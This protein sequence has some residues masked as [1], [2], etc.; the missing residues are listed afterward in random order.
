[1]K[2]LKRTMSVLLVLILFVVSCLA[3]FALFHRGTYAFDAAYL[4]V[5]DEMTDSYYLQRTPRDIKFRVATA[6][7][8]ISPTYN[9]TDAAGDPVLSSHERV[10]Q[11]EYN[12]LP[13]AGG[14]AAGARYTLT[15]GDDAS[16]TDAHLKNARTL[17]FCIE[18]DAAAEYAFTDK[19]TQTATPIRQISADVISLD[20]IDAQ[21]G[22]ILFGANESNDYVVCKISEIMDDGT[23]AVTV[24]ALDEIYADLSV[25]GE[26]EFDVNELAS[27]PALEGEITENVRQSNFYAALMTTAYAAEP[28]ED[29]ALKVSITPDT[30]T[31]SL[32]IEIQITLKPGENGLFDIREL[33]NHEVS[34]TLK[35]TLGLKVLA[36]IQ[37]IANWDISGSV[38]SGFTW[39]VEITRILMD[40]EWESGL[41]ELFADQDA[42]N[43]SAA[44][45]Q[46]QKNIRQ[47][48]AALN[49]IAA[50]AAGGEIKIFDW[51]LPVPS[52]PGLYFSAEVKLFAKFEMTASVV[53]GQQSTTIYTVGVCFSDHTFRAYSNTYRSGEDVSLSLRGKATAKAGVKLV[54]SATLISD[55]VARI[56]VDPQVGLYADAYATIPILGAGKAAADN[57]LY[58]YFEPGVYFSAN[59]NAHL[60][61]LVRQF[62]FN[63]ELI[64]KKFPIEAWTLGNAKIATGIA[65]SAASVR[66]VDHTVNLP[67]ILFEY[68][69]VKRGVNATEKI[70]FDKLKF[71]SNEGAQ[72]EAANG[73]LTLPT[74]TSSGSCYV[75][76]TYL[77]TDGKSYSTIF[78]V[79]ISGS[80]LEGKVS[81]YTAALSTGVVEGA[82]V[83]LYTAAGDAP[84]STQ[85]TD[86]NGKFSFHVSEGNYRLVIRA[87]GYRTLT[88]NQRVDENEIKYTEH[89]LL[90]DSSQSGDGTAG[91]TVSNALTGKGVSGAA[92]KLRRDWNNTSGAYAA[93]FETTTNAA[94]RYT[95]SDVPAGYYTVEASM[96]GYVTGYTNILVLSDNP[97]T[98][99]DFTITPEL[100]EDEV[101]IVLTWGAS[102]SDLDSHLIGR[103][104][105]GDAFNVYYRDKQYRFDGIEM[106]NLDVDDT[107]SYGPETITITE[108]IHD[109]Y[110]YAVH[111][112]S[113]R[114][115][116]NSTALSFSGAIVRVFIGSTQV[117][118]YHVPADQT[119]TYWT[120]FQIAGG[121]R[122]VPI[123]T[124]SNTSPAA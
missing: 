84:V 10:S 45:K 56:N 67:D 16:F 31:N 103:T 75:T 24:P 82:Q 61:I 1:M 109:V 46:Y 118:E 55:K 66:A 44:Q 102:P 53:I 120:V 94:G 119:G 86:E 13:P 116:S 98:D 30:R 117:A 92:L 63:Y 93:G 95:I 37:G 80:M 73:K 115:S 48:T 14:Y 108:S 85:A 72:L 101:R 69:D 7:L 27:N 113:N 89:I 71:V 111:N 124:V 49:Q 22:E 17:V 51:K 96:D 112:Y 5:F 19:V 79:L 35:S 34:V 90:M 97:K 33:R 26:Y 59:V 21:P 105:R 68:Y 100:A 8:E 43:T 25:Y 15:L 78:R 29:G 28:H 42:D 11:T 36:N 40:E 62:D 60:N 20:G 110:T 9:V 77:H 87:D 91:G 2:R 64:E 3:S 123:N 74:A 39:E 106:A 57:F 99:F 58:S 107:S 81:A 41:E 104:P 47:I 23:A 50:D 12:I 4:S 65:S 52:V 70:S 83:A 88:S 76:A 54:I 38:T 32:A 18:R 6:A 122:I 121:H 114:S